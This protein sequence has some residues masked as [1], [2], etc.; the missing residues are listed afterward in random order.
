MISK[1]NFIKSALFGVSI[2]FVSAAKQ[3]ADVLPMPQTQEKFGDFWEQ[4][5]SEYLLKNDYINLENGYYSM[6][7]QPVM[8]SYID[9]IKKINKEAS[10]YFRTVQFENR[11]KVRER[12]SNLL[13]CDK[14][15]LIV[16]RNTTE[17]L[18][19]VI[20]GFDWKQGDEAIM[21]EQ[22]Y[23]SMLDMFKQQELRY[24]ITNRIISIPLHPTSDEQIVEL[25]ENAINAKTRLIMVC[26][27]INTTGQILPIKK[28]C[29]M[30]QS[31]GVQVM[32]DGAHAIAH[33]DFKIS[34]LNC[35]YYGSSLHKW[36][37]APLGAGILYINKKNTNT[38][39][40]IYGDEGFAKD[41]IRKLNHLGTHPVATELSILHAI[42]YHERIGIQRKET[43]LRFLKDYW[44]TKLKNTPKINTNTP[45]ETDR[46]CGI[47]NVG[48]EGVAPAKLA[49]I[50][51]EKYKIWTVAIDK[52]NV[53]GVRIT[54]HLYTTTNELDS[55]VSALKEIANS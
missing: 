13:G 36:L 22:D 28:I 17:S 39:W 41:D 15:E 48:I 19:T 1:R 7:A 14:E 52:S 29:Q 10:Y 21:A 12:L 55:L 42:D 25:Y 4:I 50:L 47:A 54:P 26:H 34:E 38:L 3:I 24:G 20:S 49:K 40:P 9:E 11:A 46:S 43:R 35:N 5:R 23:G 45:T 6:M 30:A 8:Q 16:T 18:D 53:H 51:L 33:I 31:K 27:M 32:V 44:T 37:G 2:P